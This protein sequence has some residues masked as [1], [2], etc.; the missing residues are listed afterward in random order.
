MLP[1][2]IYIQGVFLILSINLNNFV[3]LLNIWD[4]KIYMGGGLWEGFKYQKNPR[5]KLN[6]IRNYLHLSSDLDFLIS[7]AI[8]KYVSSFTVRKAKTA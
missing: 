7:I 4:L 5:E 3:V 2:G 1:L 6:E 8:F